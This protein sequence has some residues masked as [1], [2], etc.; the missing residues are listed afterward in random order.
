MNNYYV[1]LYMREDL[2]SPWYV[3]S[4]T[5]TRCL[6]KHGKNDRQPPKDRNLI[7]KVYE[8]TEKECRELESM[9]I[10]FYG[11]KGEGVLENQVM[12]TWDLPYL[13]EYKER[14]DKEWYYFKNGLWEL[15][16]DSIIRS[17]I[18]NEFV[19]IIKN[20]CKRAKEK[21]EA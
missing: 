12:N 2:Y 15:S 4:G 21:E 13:V 7:R 8:G 14:K 17:K 10:L 6:K 11:I 1:Y 18:S 5:G 19:N 16:G 9:L 3:G 20:F